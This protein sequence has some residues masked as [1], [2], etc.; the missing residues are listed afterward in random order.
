MKNNILLACESSCDETSFCLFDVDKKI[1]LS[2]VI[3]SQE[4]HKKYGGVVPELCSKEHLILIDDLFKKTLENANLKISDISL[5]A[6]TNNPGLP[7]ALLIGSSYVKALAWSEKKDFIPVNHLMGHIY[8]ASI[9]NEIEYPNICLSVSGGHTA[10]YYVKNEYEYEI[11]G[12]TLDDAAGECFDKISKLLG[13]GYPGGFIIEKYAEKNNFFDFYK[14]PRLKKKDLNFSFSGLKTAVLYK[15]IEEGLYDAEKKMGNF[16]EIDLINISS[17]ILVCI[18]DIL[19][20]KIKI[21]FKKNKEIKSISFVGGVAC[22]NFI[23]NKIKNFCEKNFLKYYSPKKLYCTDNAAM[24]A[25]VASN[26]Y[27]KNKEKY[28]NNYSTGIFHD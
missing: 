16:K 9:E 2:H 10:I 23:N 13:L 11:L 28:I 14:F 3:N 12:K 15:L 5:F 6:A 1:V 18:S 7:G 27:K 19:L 20:E 24:I 22:N 4:V 8:S 25:L 17:S 26:L 21:A